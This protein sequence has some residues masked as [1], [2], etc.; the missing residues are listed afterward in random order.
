MSIAD[1]WAEQVEGRQASGAEHSAPPLSP[2]PASR[3]AVGGV[4]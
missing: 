4:E 3:I 1:A 2:Y